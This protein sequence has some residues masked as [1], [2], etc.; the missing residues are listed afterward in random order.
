M[1]GYGAVADVGETLINL[2]RD[3]IEELSSPESVVLA[4]PRDARGI[5]D[6]SLSIFLYQVL[7]NT[8]LKNREPGA[9]GHTSFSFPPVALD[10]YYMLTTYPSGNDPLTER[11]Q[12]AH[13]LMG[14][15]IQVLNDN[16]ILTGSVLSEG[17]NPNEELH[18]IIVSPTLDDLTKIWGTFQDNSS[19]HPSICYLI[20]PVMIDSSRAMSVQ[21]VVSKETDHTYMVP[22]KGEK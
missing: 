11:T 1:S 18:V 10:L 5:N 17:L 21:R 9:V 2:L 20:T 3:N 16:P 6:V 13:R 22:E 19:F 14:R 15:V 7:E 8:H 4:S 12:Q